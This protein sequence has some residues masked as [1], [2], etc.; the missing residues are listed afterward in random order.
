MKK[1][2]GMERN[3]RKN[4]AILLV[5]KFGFGV[6]PVDKTKSALVKWK[7]LQNRRPSP[8][9][10]SGWFTKWPETNIGIVT[11]QVSNLTV[12]DTDDSK[13]T[14]FI[15]ALLPESFACPIAKTP[16]GGRH[17]YFRFEGQIR[18]KI[19]LFPRC[20]IR[21][22]GSFVLA[23]PSV[24]KAGTPYEWERSPFDVEIPAMPPD[25]RDT[26]LALQSP[27]NSRSWAST[28][29]LAQGSRNDDLFHIANV[30]ARHSLGR[31]R[32]G[33]IVLRLA[34]ICTPPVDPE[35]AM[36]IVESAL[37]RNANQSFG[38]LSP[39]LI[40]LSDIAPEPMS[41][42]W[43]G[44]IPMGKL[45]LVVGNPD[46]G[47]SLLSIDVAARVTSGR[48]WPG[49]DVRPR[50]GSVIL[51]TAEDGLADTVR[52]RADAAGADVTKIKVLQGI[53]TS[54]D[55]SGVLYREIDRFRP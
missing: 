25:L 33:G 12:V 9:E 44:R 13:A 47:K 34:A 28:G 29:F 46:L 35:E 15:K 32:V 39:V 5:A 55:G 51:L 50:P 22:Q 37:A 27:G 23:P 11:G 19:G 53:R 48:P 7:D 24:G 38:A 10:V 18:N 42:L 4:A 36:K 45:T 2:E 21:T 49:S 41:W 26:L 16:R 8:E 3:L 17:F 31:E 6:I 43:P 14:Q 52:I 40:N 54:G 30:L 1:Q 20:D